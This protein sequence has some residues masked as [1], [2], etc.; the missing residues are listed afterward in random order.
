[1]NPNRT[2]KYRS[3]RQ[4][5]DLFWSVLWPSLL[6][7]AIFLTHALLYAFTA[8][9][10]QTY[11]NAFLLEKLAYGALAVLAYGFYRQSAR[12]LTLPEVAPTN[13][14]P[15]ESILAALLAALC[16]Y[17]VLRAFLMLVGAAN[18]IERPGSSGAALPFALLISGLLTPAAE[19]LLYRAGLFQFLSRSISRSMAL[20]LSTFCF[21]IVHPIASAPFMVLCGLVFGVLYWRYGLIPSILAHV[22]YNLLILL[23]AG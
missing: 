2:F 15:G 10:L 22:V 18:T 16:L 21:A 19:E 13:N 14:R 23:S 6:G 12:A 1:M 7:I 8:Q 4:K 20:I 9:Q 11:P 17:G 3:P 5:C